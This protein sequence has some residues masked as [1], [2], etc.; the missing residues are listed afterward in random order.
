MATEEE[1]CSSILIPSHVI[2]ILRGTL[3]ASAVGISR[4]RLRKDTFV[5][6]PSHVMFFVGE[7]PVAIPL[8]KWKQPT[9]QLFR[10]WQNPRMIFCIFVIASSQWL[11]LSN[12]S[13]RLA[14][15][16]CW[17]SFCICQ[18]STDSIAC[19][20]HFTWNSHV[21]SRWQQQ[22]ALAQRYLCI[23]S[24]ACNIF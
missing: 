3:K 7:D 2:S 8:Y 21:I 11:Q 14:A 23:D 1:L 22:M 20:I 9:Q 18:Y 15:Y 13:R 17:G 16:L 5:L 19:H 4:W 10:R 24:F 12:S 6:I